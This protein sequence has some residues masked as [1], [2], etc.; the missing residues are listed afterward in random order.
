[1]EKSNNDGEK[2]EQTSGQKLIE[3]LTQ[4]LS[5]QHTLFHDTQKQPYIAI[6]HSGA[7]VMSL[8]GNDFKYW[9]IANKMESGEYIS[10]HTIDEITQRLRAIAVYKSKMPRPLSVRIYRKDDIRG[11]PQ[12]LWYDLG[13]A[14]GLAVQITKDGYFIKEPPIIFRKYDHQHEQVL[15]S[16]KNSGRLED[17]FNIVNLTEREDKVAFAVFLVS[18]FVDRFPKPVLLVRG[19]NGSGKSTPMRILH[20]IID[21]SELEAGTSLVK[22]NSELARVANKCAILHFDNVD[23]REI[24]PEVSNALCRI[25]SGQA[26]VK[27]TL[28]S[29]DDDTIF[30]GQRAVMLNGIGKLA[31]REDLLDR[32]LIFNMKRIPEEKR[33][34]EAAIFA[35][36]EEMKPYLLHEIFMILSM[37]ISI[38]PTVE[39]E[40]THR[41]ADFDKLGYAI[42]E[43][44]DGYSGEEWLE[45]CDK[46]FKRQIE[47][48]FEASA[49]AQI[50]KFLVDRSLGHIWEGTA[51]EMFNF[52]LREEDH[53]QETLEDK[54]LK[55]SIRDNPSFPKS[56]NVLG[57]QLNRAESTLRSLGIIVEH[58]KDGKNVYKDGARWITLRDYGWIKANKKQEQQTT[59][60]IVVPF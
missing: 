9:L 37:V 59:S 47:N 42:C 11:M 60:D 2:P 29:N 16:S 28:Y 4:D 10:T 12:E 39:L 25:T 8:N 21:P 6:N 48:A 14:D 20:N 45:I 26:F 52:A 41:L 53:Y 40:N 56:P 18:C 31:E 44:M 49:T 32:C 58:S 1:M 50:A 55:Q 15:P 23:G 43:A 24:T 7:K 38:Y 46:V 30:K 51:T 17:L 19:T 33:K 36:L 35:K 57:V 34:T 54:N 22:D 13:R 27:R 3:K 5:E